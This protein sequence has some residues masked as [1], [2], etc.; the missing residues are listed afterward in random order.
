MKQ[1]VN[2]IKNIFLRVSIPGKKGML[3]LS[4]LLFISA[5]AF[6]TNEQLVKD[7]KEAYDKGKYEQAIANYEKIISTGYTS[8]ALYYNLGNAYYKNDRI[9]K[10]IYYYELAHKL[11]PTDE[12]IKHNLTIVNKRTKDQIEQKENYFAKNIEAGILNFLSTS[13]WAWLTIIAL[14][15]ACIFY[16]LFKITER[17]KLKRLFF[18]IGTLALLKCVA[19]LIIGF[20]ALNNI[21]QKTQAIILS[22]EVSILNAPT[23]DAK[24]QFTLHEGTKVHVLE[25]TA[26]WTAI[27]L[28]NG[29]EGWLPTKD[30]G[31][32]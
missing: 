28:D 12:N 22:A 8:S 3:C 4:L 30:I 2:H 16:V 5:T 6:S 29:N 15:F 21:E 14:S 24:P 19:G 1:K 13:G 26:T 20:M 10:A 23:N 7:A 31:L 25:T 27:S 17:K 11:E 9:G 32:F 18:W